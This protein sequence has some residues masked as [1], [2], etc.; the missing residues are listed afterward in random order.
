MSD[1][2]LDITN[3]DTLLENNDQASYD[4]P[5]PQ[6][7][8]QDQD[9]KDLAFVG[10]DEDTTVLVDTKVNTEVV[11]SEEE[12]RAKKMIVIGKRIR[13]ASKLGE[14]YK[15]EMFYEDKKFEDKEELESLL[16][17]MKTIEKYADIVSV[18][19]SKTTYFYSSEHMTINYAN[20][21]IRLEDKDI[22][23]TIAET[24]RFDSKTYPQP[25]DI[26][27]FSDRPYHFP[28]EQ[29]LEAIEA[30]KSREEYSD[31]QSCFTSNGLHFLF[32]NQHMERNYAEA[33]AQWY[34]VDLLNNP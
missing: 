8:P 12:K 32:S 6:P 1:K 16:A 21:M 15:I 19:G 13:K 26:R 20:I 18:N 11:E 3:D 7:Q 27:V 14:I 23:T 28:E 9:D 10:Y 5:E 31:I 22:F 29:V 30:M 17:E 2:E 34:G 24:T 25:T 33:L 4:Q